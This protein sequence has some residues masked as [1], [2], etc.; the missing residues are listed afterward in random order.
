MDLWTIPRH[1]KRFVVTIWKPTI[2]KATFIALMPVIASFF[3]SGSWVNIDT[4]GP[5][6]NSDMMKPRR[7]TNVPQKAV[8]VYT[9]F[10][11]EYCRAP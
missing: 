2:G 9:S 5:E 6:R 8:N 11:L 3:S 4:T 10:T 7:V 1:W